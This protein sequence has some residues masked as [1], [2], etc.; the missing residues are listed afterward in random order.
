[1]TARCVMCGRACIPMADYDQ[2]TCIACDA[3]MDA[4]NPMI[5]WQRAEQRVERR[6]RMLADLEVERAAVRE[7]ATWAVMYAHEAAMSDARTHWVDAA[8]F[9]RARR[10]LCVAGT[11]A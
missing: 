1:M 4:L 9:L 6:A 3:L 8:T 10:G 2:P 7:A 5:D 11:A